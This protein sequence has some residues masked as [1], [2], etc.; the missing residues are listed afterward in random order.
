MA[1]KIIAYNDTQ[2]KVMEKDQESI[3]NVA[4]Q[5]ICRLF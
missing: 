4:N 2:I 5:Q 3:K 1:C